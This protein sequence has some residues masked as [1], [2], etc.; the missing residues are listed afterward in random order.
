MTWHA[1]C[2]VAH[3]GRVWHNAGMERTEA[4][5]VGPQGR[6]VIPAEMRRELGISAGDVLLVRA[7]ADRLVL[8]KREALLQRLR[9]RFRQAA[10]AGASLADELIAERRAVSRRE[11]V[12]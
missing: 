12:R 3:R 7:E 4:V 9:S 2:H 5:T 1:C 6:L 11:D 10:A 8:E